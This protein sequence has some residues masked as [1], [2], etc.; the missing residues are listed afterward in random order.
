MAPLVARRGCVVNQIP[1]GIDVETK[2]PLYATREQMRRNNYVVGGAP[3]SYKSWKYLVPMVL[4]LMAPNEHGEHE[5]IVIL[6]LSADHAVANSARLAAQSHG[7]PFEI[8]VLDNRFA[9]RKLE[10]LESRRFPLTE[11]QLAGL[12]LAGGGIR[13][14]QRQNDQFFFKNNEALAVEL[15]RAMIRDGIPRTLETIYEQVR[16]RASK[17]TAAEHLVYALGALLGFD[18]LV[19][20]ADNPL[21]WDDILE[22][23]GVLY[24][25]APSLD[26]EQ[27]VSAAAMIFQSLV[28]YLR[29]RYA[30]GGG[31]RHVHLFGDDIAPLLHRGTGK[32]LS[33]ARKLGL[34]VHLLIQSLG[35][36][37]LEDRGVSQTL[38]A[39][40]QTHI[41]FT[42][43]DVE[44]EH[45]QQHS[46]DATT[47][48]GG[49][50]RGPSGTT[51]STRETP[52]F[53]MTRN[54]ILDVADQPGAAIVLRRD[55]SGTVADSE[56]RVVFFEFPYPKPFHDLMVRTPLPLAQQPGAPSEPAPF[57]WRN[58]TRNEAFDARA[59]LIAA[60]FTRLDE[61][62]TGEGIG[63]AQP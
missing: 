23:G 46:R 34:S 41:F 51:V 10:V 8:V 20:E 60:L 37:E 5:A 29:G 61:A 3:G 24:V 57:G 54:R 26:G 28:T 16:I 1:F 45:I 2:Q 40:T 47:E 50:T 15:G 18:C 25:Y 49:M 21:Y 58:P 14:G 38:L 53:R 12:L 39:T 44:I 9:G 33:L 36:L 32:I 55:Q 52:D 22:V 6:D 62:L 19:G 31:G 4:N 63:G 30:H 27:V 7:V 13:P 59:T 17:Y 42:P 11:V 48:L 35:Q 56:P 43:Y